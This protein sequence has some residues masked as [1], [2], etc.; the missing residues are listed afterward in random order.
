MRLFLDTNILYFLIQERDEISNDVRRLFEDYGNVLYTSSVCVQE[1]IHLCQT[2]KIKIGKK[3][4]VIQKPTDVFGLLDE[5]GIHIVPVTI[6]HLQEY[7]NLPLW[8]EHSDPNDRLIIAQAMSDKI[9]LVSSD[10]KFKH[11]QQYGL[12]F[13][14]NKR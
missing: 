6:K 13:L 2:E 3:S 11:Y 8:K 12:E 5:C 14:F 9:C 7:A 10:L 1:L 4:D